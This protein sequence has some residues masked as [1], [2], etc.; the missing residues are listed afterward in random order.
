MA[1]G[2]VGEEKLLADTLTATS[3]S[4]SGATAPSTQAPL[5]MG[6][7]GVFQQ[8]THCLTTPRMDAAALIATVGGQA[9]IYVAGGYST[10]SSIENTVE[11]A[12]ISPSGAQLEAFQKLPQTLAEK[13]AK[14]LLVQGNHQSSPKV[15]ANQTYLFAAGGNND[16]GKTWASGR[17]STLDNTTGSTGNWTAVDAIKNAPFGAV[18]YLINNTFY[19]FGG[20]DTL[21]KPP[22]K[23]AVSCI[24]SVP[25]AFSNCNSLGL[26]ALPSPRMNA[27][28]TLE[29]A[30]FYIAGGGPN[31]TGASP[32]VIK[33][34]Y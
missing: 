17:V 3:H 21:Q 7:T 29:S 24:F 14:L 15:P 9:R 26:G 13:R 16:G 10:N 4:D 28:I 32:S 31:D 1:N 34:V 6:S 11:L 23:E 19:Y 8:I 20:A 22:T 18:G 2:A 5:R 12:T 27:A 33:T 25:P 30:F